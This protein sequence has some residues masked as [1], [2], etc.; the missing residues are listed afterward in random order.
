MVYYRIIPNSEF[1]FHYDGEFYDLEF[2]GKKE[3]EINFRWIGFC[4]LFSSFL[5]QNPLVGPAL[6]RAWGLFLWALEAELIFRV[7]RPIFRRTNSL[8]GFRGD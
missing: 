8:E 3:R 6:G 1:P 7:L 4:P 2:E 5:F